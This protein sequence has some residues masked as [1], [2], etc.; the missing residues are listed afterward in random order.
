MTAKVI[1]FFGDI[2]LE[3]ITEG[4][5]AY[6]PLLEKEMGGTVINV[7]NLES[8]LT[9]SREEKQHQAHI[10]H[11]LPEKA[12][13]LLRPFRIVSLANNH[14]QDFFNKG[15]EDTRCWLDKYGIQYFGVGKSQEEAIQPLCMD[16]DGLR[17]AFIGASR[18]ANASAQKQGTSVE[19]LGILR[20]LIYKLKQ[21]GWSVVMFFHWGYL[22]QRL[23]SPRE[24]RIAHKC[25]DYGA[26]LVLGAHSHVF[27][28]HERYRGKE[29][30]YGL[31]NFIF[32][33]QVASVLSDKGDRR[34]LESFFLRVEFDGGRVISCLP[35]WYRIA[36]K[37]V[38]MIPHEISQPLEQ[39]LAC[40]S[41]DLVG[42]GLHYRRMYYRQA[43]KIAKQSRKMRHEFQMAERISWKDKLKIYMDFNFQDVCNRV[44]ALFPCFFR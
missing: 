31:G 27:Q 33:P 24:V 4:A 36:N 1:Q 19:R 42:G 37:Y 29:I 5:F 20:S 7:G 17:I 39:E 26:D 8:P 34:V 13:G 9:S 28:A 30:W 43:V 3:N 22:Y 15:I 23:P 18:Y 21:E 38:E 41:A 2:C 32:H 12:I 14:I 11:C 25:I 6:G 35:M 16:F 44:A 10:L 40:C